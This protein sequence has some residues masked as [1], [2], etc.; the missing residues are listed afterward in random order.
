MG[1][2]ETAQQYVD[3]LPEGQ[4]AAYQPIT[5]SQWLSAIKARKVQAAIGPDGIGPFGVCRKAKQNPN[6]Q[7]EIR[8]GKPL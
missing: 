6:P 4:E 8:V 3:N 1:H 2:W 5:V 7:I